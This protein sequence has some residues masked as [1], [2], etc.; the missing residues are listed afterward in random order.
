MEYRSPIYYLTPAEPLET[1]RLVAL[2]RQVVAAGV[3]LV[4][5]RAKDLPTRRMYEDVAALL[6]VT[7]PAGVPLLVNDRVEVALAAGAEGVHLGQEDLPVALTRRLLGPYAIL[8][9]SVE[10]PEQARQAVR[11]GASYVACG[12][13]FP[14]L[15]K[16]E[17][18]ARG[19]MALAAIRR[20][21]SVPLC[22]IGGISA[23]NLGELREVHPEL[24]AVITAI[25]GAPDPA[26][27]ARELVAAA[28]VLWPSPA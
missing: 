8:G 13:I 1:P 4:Q 25:N 18:P 16:P 5:Y 23:A 24:I 20:V 22:A 12:P 2:V 6:A 26:A 9:V 17:C 27:A 28:K 19:V 10:S 14:S 7:R 3:G 11:D 15:V 21:V